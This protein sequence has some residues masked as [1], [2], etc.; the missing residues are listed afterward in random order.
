MLQSYLTSQSG[1]CPSSTLSSQHGV[2]V[3]SD[4][5]EAKAQSTLLLASADFELVGNAGNKTISM[6]FK[7]AFP[8]RT[9]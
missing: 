5:T 3:S 6:R 7:Q 4:D 9:R 8:R 2:A 1:S